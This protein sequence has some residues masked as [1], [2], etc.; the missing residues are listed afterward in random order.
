MPH[1]YQQICYW[2]SRNPLRP[3]RTPLN[4]ETW[5]ALESLCSV[6]RAG[7]Q[8]LPRK[9]RDYVSLGSGGCAKGFGVV[10]QRSRILLLGGIPA[11][12]RPETCSLDLQQQQPEA[13]LL[14]AA[15][16]SSGCT[17]SVEA[18]A[19]SF[20]IFD[21][22]AL[23]NS[24]GAE[25]KTESLNVSPSSLQEVPENLRSHPTLQPPEA[26]TRTTTQWRRTRRKRMHCGSARRCKAHSP[27]PPLPLSS[28]PPPSLPLLPSP[29][30]P[31]PPP[32]PSPS[33]SLPSCLTPVID[34]HVAC[35]ISGSCSRP[36]DVVSFRFFLSP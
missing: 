31:L 12:P 30:P 15:R 27:S 2:P 4:A 13:A 21:Q 7:Q 28:S 6:V 8:T 29:F 36:R 26:S 32:S 20:K 25:A 9:A 3:R 33:I 19:L 11:N 1:L 23:D 18:L 35:R 17:Y 5:N 24:L 34:N 14:K 10:D 16:Y 22:R